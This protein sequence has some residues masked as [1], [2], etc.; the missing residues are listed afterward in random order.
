MVWM[1][2]LL[3]FSSRST[4]GVIEEL[5]ERVGMAQSYSCASTRIDEALTWLWPLGL[6]FFI[7]QLGTRILL[8]TLS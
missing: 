7:H 8:R 4:T 3:P 5:A 1:W 2:T 6:S